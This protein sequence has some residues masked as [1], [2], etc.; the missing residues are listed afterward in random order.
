MLVPFAAGHRPVG[1]A[2]AE[3]VVDVLDTDEM[4]LE[5]VGVDAPISWPVMRL[6]PAATM[7]PIVPDLR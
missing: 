2:D 4:L 5:L 3:L 7:L 1:V 6:D